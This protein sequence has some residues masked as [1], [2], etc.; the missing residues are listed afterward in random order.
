MEYPGARISTGLLSGAEARQPV[1]HCSA[2]PGIY[3]AH[4]TV[5]KAATHKV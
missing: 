5:D 4:G 2:A 3:I 1:R